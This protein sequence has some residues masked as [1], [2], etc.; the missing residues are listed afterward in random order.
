MKVNILPLNN[1]FVHKNENMLNYENSSY[2]LIICKSN[3]SM[4]FDMAN[5]LY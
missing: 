5:D 2:E 3:I 1:S 4:G